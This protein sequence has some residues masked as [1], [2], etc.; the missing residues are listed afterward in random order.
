[1]RY[2]APLLI[3]LMLIGLVVVNAGGVSEAWKLGRSIL[4]VLTGLVILVALF[5]LLVTK[6]VL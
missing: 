3:M 4:I 6:P 5:A 2:A 1:M